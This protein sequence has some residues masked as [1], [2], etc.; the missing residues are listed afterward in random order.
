MLLQAAGL[1]EKSGDDLELTPAGR[2]AT[3]A[4]AHEVSTP[5]WSKWRT[6]TLLDE[7]SRVDDDQGAGQGRA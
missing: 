1:A 2:K 4:T 7:F 6:S 3:G 5:I